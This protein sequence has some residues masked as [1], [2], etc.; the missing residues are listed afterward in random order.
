MEVL[1][2]GCGYWRSNLIA[3]TGICA[4]CTAQDEDKVVLHCIECKLDKVVKRHE[5]RPRCSTC[6]NR[7]RIQ[8]DYAY[9]LAVYARNNRWRRNQKFSGS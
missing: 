4:Y 7:I 2:I 5:I 6:R 8:T 9:R 1:C 3:R